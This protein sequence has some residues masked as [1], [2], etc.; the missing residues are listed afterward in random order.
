M[1]DIRDD[2]EKGRRK[3]AKIIIPRSLH[4]KIFFLAEEVFEQFH[5]EF[6]A[7]AEAELE[8]KDGLIVVKVGQELYLP[9]QTVTAGSA[10]FDDADYART[11]ADVG[12]SRLHCWIHSHGA[13]GVF[14]SS[15]D[16]GTI[17]RHAC[18]TWL[19]SIVINCRKE[20]RARVDFPLANLKE[21]LEPEQNFLALILPNT[22]RFEASVEVEPMLK[23]SEKEALRQLI[24]EKITSAE[25]KAIDSPS[26]FGGKGFS[27]FP[28][29]YRD[30]V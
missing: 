18:S 24:A 12:G 7:L 30:D 20:M 16:E 26:G 10:V 29:F 5:G 15:T 8:V 21:K 14:W 27:L 11:L 9:R 28:Y 25:K 23:E 1:K 2:E 3:R 22:I 17:A 4:E 13:N 19:A 6:Q